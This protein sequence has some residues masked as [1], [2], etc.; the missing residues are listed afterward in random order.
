MQ[1]P[2]VRPGLAQP[3]RAQRV[4]DRARRRRRRAAP[5]GSARSSSESPPNASAVARA[6][7]QREPGEPDARRSPSVRH[8]IVAIRPARDH[9]RREPERDRESREAPTA[10]RRPSPSGMQIDEAERPPAARA[11]SASRRR[12]RAGTSPRSRPTPTIHEREVDDEM[13][14]LPADLAAVCAAEHDAARSGRR[15]ARRR[16]RAAP[17]SDE[18]HPAGVRRR[19]GPRPPGRCRGASAAPTRSARARTPSRRRASRR[20]DRRTRSS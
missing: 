1:P 19:G 14:E 6:D 13:P 5:P 4:D 18:A 7:D 15:R 9:E 12:T 10:P 16:R 17:T 2:H 11:S 3:E 20:R 8:E